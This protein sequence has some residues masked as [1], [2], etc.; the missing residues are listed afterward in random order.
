MISTSKL[1]LCLFLLTGVG[2]SQNGPK[3]FIDQPYIEVSGTVEAE[4]IPNEIFLKIVLSEHNSKSKLS[5]EKQE[6]LMITALNELGINTGESLSVS[7]FSGM[8]TRNFLGDS[9]LKKVKQYQL[10]L[11]DGKT[12]GEVYQALDQCDISNIS[13][14]ET[15]HTEIEKFR[16]ETKLKA[17][18]IAKEKAKDYAITIGQDIGKALLIQELGSNTFASQMA[19]N[20]VIGNNYSQGYLKQKSQNINLH[21]IVIKETVMVKFILN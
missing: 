13:I 9:N 17:L 18:K 15:S 6:N 7:D 2:F 4:I 10:V 16:R 11:S 1:C 19:S 3:N 20:N 12:L 5:I 21:P 14:T 8:Y